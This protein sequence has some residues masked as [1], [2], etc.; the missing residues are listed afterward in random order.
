MSTKIYNGYKINSTDLK[1]LQNLSLEI[2][3]K[4]RFK[5]KE[6]C[7]NTIIRFSI[8]CLDDHIHF[9]KKIET[10]C[11]PAV[12][13][14]KKLESII[15]NIQ[16]TGQRNCM[17]DFD[18]S[19]SFIPLEDYT[20]I[21]A[22]IEHPELIK[23]WDQHKQIEY[24]GYWDNT[25]PDEDVSENEWLQRG[26]DW[27]TLGDEPPVCVGFSFNIYGKYN[28]PTI[29]TRNDVKEDDLDRIYPIENRKYNIARLMLIDSHCKNANS[30]SD[31]IKYLE[32]ESAKKELTKIQKKLNI[33]KYKVQDLF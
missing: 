3:D 22:Y 20:L 11:S 21:L 27:D 30:I 18:A 8:E 13:A 5:V 9:G 1:Y 6:L 29:V 31:I 24:Y 17:Y 33:Q 19:W 7:Y 16:K 14:W 25:D 28:M 2:R 4:M 32:T 23:I 15:E 26:K 10:N 12:V